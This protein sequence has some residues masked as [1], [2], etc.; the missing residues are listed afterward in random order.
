MCHNP[1]PRGYR[2]THRIL[3]HGGPRPHIRFAQLYRIQ[4]FGTECEYAEWTFHG[5]FSRVWSTFVLLY[6]PVDG[7]GGFVLYFEGDG[8]LHPEE[9]ECGGTEETDYGVGICG[10]SVCDVLVCLTN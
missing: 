2:H 7:D 6:V 3:L 1:N 9:D 4:V 5:T 10:E 8:E